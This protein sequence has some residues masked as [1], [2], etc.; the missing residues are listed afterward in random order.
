[1]QLNK[2]IPFNVICFNFNANKIEEYDIMKELIEEYKNKKKKKKAP[3]TKEEFADLVKSYSLWKWWGRCEYEILIS[4]WPNN[5]TT[6]KWDIH[7][8]I[9]M[10]LDLIVYVLMNNVIKK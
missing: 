9:L 8:Q 2:Y 4:D 5:K 7:K 6:I 10:N 1:M 3:K